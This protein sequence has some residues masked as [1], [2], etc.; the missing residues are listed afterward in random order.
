[1]S[2]PAS[3]LTLRVQDRYSLFVTILLRAG[4][5]Q[6]QLPRT[7]PG[8]SR[9]TLTTPLSRGR[10]PTSQPGTNLVLIVI[11]TGGLL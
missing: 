2:T 9:G 7:N 1:M 3:F 11:P 10:G 8:N 6:L 4:R 5:A